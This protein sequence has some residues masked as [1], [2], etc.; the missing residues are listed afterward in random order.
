[1]R[2]KRSSYFQSLSWNLRLKVLGAARG[3]A[4]LQNPDAKVIYLDFKCSIILISFNYNAKRF[5]DL[6]AYIC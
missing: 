6:M 2:G 3:L 5:D 1:M 4:Y